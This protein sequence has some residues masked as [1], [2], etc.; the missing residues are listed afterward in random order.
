MFAVLSNA[1][2]VRVSRQYRS[3]IRDCQEEIHKD[4][5]LSANDVTK[6]QQHSELLYKLELIW[7]LVEL[8]CIEKQPGKSFVQ[9][10]LIWWSFI[11]Y[12]LQAGASS[13]EWI[14][15]YV[16]FSSSHWSTWL[17]HSHDRYW[18]QFSLDIYQGSDQAKVFRYCEL[19]RVDQ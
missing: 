17:T 12:H 10:I 7:N 15:R 13:N 18:T 8:L 3:I 9:I 14:T 5:H 16:H 4:I 11:S 2:L 1:N 6:V 19:G